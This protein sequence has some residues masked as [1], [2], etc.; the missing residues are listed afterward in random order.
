[1]SA[2]YGSGGDDGGAQLLC[3]LIKLSARK[4]LEPGWAVE[5]SE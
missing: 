1:V 2:R 3:N 4:R 5:T